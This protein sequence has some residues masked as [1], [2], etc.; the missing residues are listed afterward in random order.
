MFFRLYSL[1]K[2]LPSPKKRPFGF[3]EAFPSAFGSIVL[4]SLF[5][6]VGVLESDR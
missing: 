3:D 5:S 6:V 2:L 1:K 4:E